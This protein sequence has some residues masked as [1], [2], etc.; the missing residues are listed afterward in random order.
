MCCLYYF[1]LLVRTFKKYK[2]VIVVIHIILPSGFTLLLSIQN[3]NEINLF[4]KCSLALVQAYTTLYSQQ[5]VAAAAC[6]LLHWHAIALTATVCG[7]WQGSQHRLLHTHAETLA[8]LQLQQAYSQ[9]PWP[10]KLRA[11]KL[12]QLYKKYVLKHNLPGLKV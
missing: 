10:G 5:K 11:F 9:C 12:L 3:F 4:W 7:V 6:S 2:K 8:W 1:F